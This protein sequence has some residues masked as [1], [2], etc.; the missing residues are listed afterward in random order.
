MANADG[1]IP[2][3][4]TAEVVLSL[5][6]VPATQVPRSALTISSA[7]DI[8]VRVVGAADKVAFVPVHL[9][10]DMQDTMWVTGVH[11]RRARDRARPGLRARRPG[12]RARSMPKRAR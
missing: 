10:E 4:I 1:K 2:D 8:G 9:V 3:G 7:G 6:P 11:G 5:T 12:G